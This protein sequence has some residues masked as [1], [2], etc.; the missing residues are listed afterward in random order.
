MPDE[1]RLERAL[2]QYLQGA[3]QSRAELARRAGATDL[4]VQAMLDE[5]IAGT[6]VVRR[7][8]H[9]GPAAYE[10][11]VFGSGRL[12]LLDQLAAAGAKAQAGKDAAP[13]PVKRPSEPL[14]WELLPASESDR[15]AAYRALANLYSDRQ[16][17][18]TELRLC[19]DRVQLARTKGDLDAILEDLESGAPPPAGPRH[20]FWKWLGWRLLG[21]PR[22][23]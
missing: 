9:R 14:R 11:T 17:S 2:L 21:G 23:E 16:I 22:P 5:L 12:H 20:A 10:L 15:L 19:R 18:R 4:Q 6:F 7:P 13:A 3:P 1:S 8:R